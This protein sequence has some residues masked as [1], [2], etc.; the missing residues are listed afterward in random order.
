MKSNSDN[1]NFLH[2]KSLLSLE[3]EDLTADLDSSTLKVP[4][5]CVFVVFFLLQG[6]E[7]GI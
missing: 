7:G 5:T 1:F 3:L 6:K 2:G 4:K